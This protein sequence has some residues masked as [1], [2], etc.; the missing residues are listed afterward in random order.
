MFTGLSSLTKLVITN[1]EQLTR[2][3]SL[4]ATLERVDLSFNAIDVIEPNAFRLLNKLEY[5]NLDYNELTAE[6]IFPAIAH[7]TN[8][9]Q[10]FLRSNTI[11]SVEGLRFVRLPRL[12]VLN[13]EDSLIEKL[14]KQTFATL[15]G[16]VNLNLGGNGITEIEAGAFDGLLNLRVLNLDHSKLRVFYFDVFES[17]SNKLG[18][19]VNLM[20]LFFDPDS[21]IS[22]RWSPEKMGLPDESMSEKEE[23]KKLEADEAARLFAKCGF[24]NQLY[25]GLG[26]FKELND[27]SFVNAIAAMDL[28]CLSYKNNFV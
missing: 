17:A 21:I 6:I 20:Q 25:V 4:P 13:L 15:P 23:N 19:P 1:F 5:L 22:V 3:V 16:L 10:F 27:S 24:R 8:L 2:I 11:D 12:R 7:L 18:S 26:Y 14:S 28:V 9:E